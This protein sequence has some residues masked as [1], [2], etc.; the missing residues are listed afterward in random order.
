MTR[1]GNERTPDLSELLQAAMSQAVDGIFVAMPG[2]VESYDSEKQT[3]NIQPLVSR[4]VLLDDGSKTIDEL[5]VIPNVPIAFS[6]GGGYFL[7]F[8]LAKGDNVL[9]VCCDRSI[10]K[11]K[12]SD[13]KTQIDPV[14]IRTNDISDAVA[15]PGFYTNSNSIKDDVSSGAI[16]GKEGGIKIHLKDDDTLEA[17]NSNGNF[18]LKPD[19]Q[20][21]VNG[22]FTVD[23]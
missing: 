19:G 21:D 17:S 10:D 13:G 18:T 5:P 14:D 6:R 9:L 23:P 4:P 15:I 2:K 12:S 22:N 3:A 11:Y 8:P 16:F 20:F 1:R 7:T